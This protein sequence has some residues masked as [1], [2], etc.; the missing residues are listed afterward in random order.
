MKEL[1]YSI[2][3]EIFVRFPGYVRGVVLA[4]DVTNGESPSEIVSLLRDAEA[5]VR[6]QLT[7]EN[8]AEHPRIKSWRE[9]Y[10]S[11]GARPSEFRS[12]IEA[13]ARR[14]LRND[15]L[16]SINAL[17]DIGNAISLRYLVPTGGHAIDVVT[18]DISLRLA[19]GD[20]TFT[21]FGSE[22]IESALAGEIIFAEGNTVLTRRWTWRQANHTLT[23]PATKAIEYNV[24]G[25]PPIPVSEVDEVC[26]QVMNLIQRFC[27]GRTR[28]EIL[29][30]EHPRIKLSE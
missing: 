11:F 30:R 23:L 2:A 6:Q 7:I 19:K 26:R 13:M 16:P 25:L 17:V 4:Y 22:Q 3:D 27:G 20:E 9:A 14:A 29:T 5:S 24:D 10:R 15:P 21:P 18:Q 8:I 28:Y 12:S 1:Y